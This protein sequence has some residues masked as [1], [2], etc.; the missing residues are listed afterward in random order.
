MSETVRATSLAFAESRSDSAAAASKE[1]A[2]M[3]TP[4]MTKFH[5]FDVHPL[6]IV[7]TPS[8]RPATLRGRPRKSAALISID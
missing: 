8:N 3:A 4:L 1:I 6:Q 5:V 2:A 7:S